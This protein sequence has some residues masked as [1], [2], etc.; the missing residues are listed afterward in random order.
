MIQALK[1]RLEIH[2]ACSDW[3][4]FKFHFIKLNRNHEMTLSN[5]ARKIFQKD[6]SE[7]IFLKGIKQY[8]LLVSVA[9]IRQ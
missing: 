2:N 9:T 6:G 7:V 8:C 1:K 3:L 4:I 5:N